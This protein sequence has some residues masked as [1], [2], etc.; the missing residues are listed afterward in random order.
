MND[1]HP[2]ALSIHHGPQPLHQKGQVPHCPGSGVLRIIVVG[3]RI[4]QPQPKLM[5]EKPIR[6]RHVLVPSL[7]Q[8]MKASNASY[9]S[10]IVDGQLSV[11]VFINGQV[12]V[13]QDL[14]QHLDQKVSA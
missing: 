12:F 11:L 14:P 1:V 6:S 7:F 2:C 10:L 5:K 3:P 13:E 4:D 9:L 8:I